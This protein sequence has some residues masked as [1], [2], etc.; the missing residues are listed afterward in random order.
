[1]D[2]N[3]LYSE[4]TD[5]IVFFFFF[6]IVAQVHLSPS[7]IPLPAPPPQSFPALAL[8]MGPLYIKIPSQQHLD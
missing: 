8:S 1:M 4:F 6:F 2:G 7:S 3:L 5:L